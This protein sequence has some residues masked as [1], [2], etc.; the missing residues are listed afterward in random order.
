MALL[1]LAA[2]LLPAVALDLLPLQQ[3]MQPPRKAVATSWFL[4]H[5]TAFPKYSIALGKPDYVEMCWKFVLFLHLFANAWE[6]NNFTGLM[7][8]DFNPCEVPWAHWSNCNASA[9]SFAAFDISPQAR[10]E[11]VA[12]VR[13]MVKIGCMKLLPPRVVG[14]KCFEGS[15][16]TS[17]KSSIELPKR[18]IFGSCI[19]FGY[20]IQTELHKI[21]WTSVSK[22]FVR[23]VPNVYL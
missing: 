9:V 22:L 18:Y 3:S 20:P 17:H 8:E 6:K 14:L 23:F 11:E 12:R 19:I 15:T 10:C 5:E 7:F 1:Y 4:Q 16:H 13:K 21:R 2:S